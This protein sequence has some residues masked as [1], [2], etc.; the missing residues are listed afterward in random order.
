MAVLSGQGQGVAKTGLPALIICEV[1]EF[2][3]AAV[4]QMGQDLLAQVIP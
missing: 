4:V 2:K 1:C 3:I